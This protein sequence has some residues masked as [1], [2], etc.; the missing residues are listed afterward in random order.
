MRISGR[1][2]ALI[3]L[4]A[5]LALSGCIADASVEPAPGPSPSPDAPQVRHAVVTKHTDG[6][7]AHFRFDDGTTEK[8]RF[9]GIDTP[10]VYGEVEH[11]GREASAYT[12][13]ALPLGADVWLETDVELRDRYGRLLAYVWLQPPSSGFV[14]E[15][16]D[17]M[18]NIRL[19][20]DGFAMVSTYPP[21]VKYVELFTVAQV[22]ARESQRGLWGD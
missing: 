5:A 14:D 18:L 9:I 13:S 3:A 2:T 1:F 7:T 16:R 12:E 6:D 4:T 20:A 17:S 10:E 15:A 8:V 22:E 19:V 11:Y 21:N